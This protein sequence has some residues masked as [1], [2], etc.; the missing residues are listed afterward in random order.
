M[1]ARPA[2]WIIASAG[3]AVPALAQTNHVEVEPNDTKADALF[4]GAIVLNPGDTITGLTASASGAG[5]D[6]FLVKTA[7]AAPGVYKH[8][9]VLSTGTVGHTFTIR[10]LNQTAA[11]AAAWPGPIGTAGATDSQTQVALTVGNTRV[12]QWY[13]FGKEEQLYVRVA[14]TTATQGE[15][16]LTLETQD[17]TPSIVDAGKWVS[18]TINITNAPSGTGNDLDLWVYDSNFNPIRGFGNDGATTL[19]GHTTATN[20]VAY[21]RRHYEPG[22]YYVATASADAI[23]NMPSPSD[24]NRRTGLLLDFPNAIV[25]NSTLAT[26][27]LHF[28]IQDAFGATNFTNTKTNAPDVHWHKFVVGGSDYGACCLPSGM[29]VQMDQTRCESAAIGG[30]FSGAGSDCSTCLPATG[31]WAARMPAPYPSVGSAGAVIGDTFYLLGGSP[32]NGLRD[33]GCWKLDLVNNLWSSIAPLPHAGSVAPQL[34]GASNIDAAVIGTDIYLVG[35]YIGTGATVINRVLRYD[36]LANTWTE[37]TSDPYPTAIYGSALV[38]HNGKLYVMSGATAVGSPTTACYRYDPAAPEGSRW[39]A[40]ASIGAGRPGMAATVIG[41]LIYCVGGE[42]TD[43]SRTDVYN[44]TLDSWTQL[45]DT[46]VARGGTSLF[47]LDG[48]PYAA[49]GGWTTF[50]NTAEVFD[51]GAW[52]AGPPVIT[53]LRSP[54]YDGSDAWLVRSTGFNGAYRANTEVFLRAPACAG[55]QCGPQDFNGDGDAGTDQDIEAF[56]ACL[57]G[58]CCETCFCQGA[59]FNGDGDI[60]TDQDI[61]AFFRVLGG[62]SC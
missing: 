59:D 40:I 20:L 57:G 19:G 12:I 17:M 62:S 43:Q 38:A 15:Y 23:N 58:T 5:L 16:V 14:G 18:G 52:T 22:T 53:G 46:T 9:L 61:E 39:A 31:V 47:N 13:G 37:I 28:T 24:D 1:L 41:D 2:F 11:T 10:G 25:S 21:L 26:H 32:S 7:P 33:P 45:P 27:H 36:T 56:F 35:G 50:T 42:A 30:T 51:A 34:G 44:I 29:C 60:G 55:N 54:A 8:K 6:Y 3:L 4:N 49:A 48:K